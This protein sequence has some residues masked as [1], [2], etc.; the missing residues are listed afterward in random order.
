MYTRTENVQTRDPVQQAHIIVSNEP[1]QQQHGADGERCTAVHRQ[2]EVQRQEYSHGG[3]WNR[4]RD[5]SGNAEAVAEK[6]AE[7]QAAA[8]ATED[9]ATVGT[10]AI[11]R[12]AQ[13][14]H[15]PEPL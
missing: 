6:A 15:T 5:S 4:W 14:Q 11:Q 3:C 10:A 2:R 8:Q 1:R 9:G 7:E 12:V 13:E